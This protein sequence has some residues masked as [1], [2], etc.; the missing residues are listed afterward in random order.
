MSLLLIAIAPVL[1]IAFYIYFRDKYEKEPIGLLLLSLLAGAVIVIPVLL[2]GILLNYLLVNTTLLSTPFY[3]AFISAGL[4][5]EGFKYLAVFL[6]IWQ[7]KN[8]N[9]K[10]DGVVYAVFV[11]LGFALVENILYVVSGGFSTGLLRA[12]TAVPLHAMVGV[13]MGFYF[14]LARF[15]PAHRRFLL[16]KALLFPVIFHG[17]YDFFIISGKPVF[18][19][20]WIPLIVYL[21]IDSFKKMKKLVKASVYRDDNNTEHSEDH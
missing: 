18:I 13:I 6:L 11:S 21:W 19:L 2:T 17:L 3:K 15:D 1:I 10:F 12:F 4:V 8:F 14:G 7:N 16:F 5:E 9:E 20:L